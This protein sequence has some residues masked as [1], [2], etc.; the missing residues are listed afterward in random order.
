MGEACCCCCCQSQSSEH[1]IYEISLDKIS[2]VDERELKRGL[3]HNLGICAVRFDFFKGKLIVDYN[4]KHTTTAEID[5]ALNT[6]G[7]II[8]T[9]LIQWVGK[10][11]EKH[12]KRIRLILSAF[13]VIVSWA[14][15]FV[16]GEH[17][18][19]PEKITSPTSIELLYILLNMFAIAIA[20]VPT[21]RGTIAAIRERKLNVS[22]LIAIASIGAVFLGDWLEAASV[23]FITVVGEALEGAALTRSNKRSC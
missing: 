6:P 5:K 17:Y 2:F 19:F 8:K 23:L 13:F 1:G 4:P 20:G 16:F 7:Y 10:T 3:E 9:N 22:V 12:G 14:M 11:A 15:L 21:L 18:S